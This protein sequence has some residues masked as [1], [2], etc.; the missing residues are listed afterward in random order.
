MKNDPPVGSTPSEVA[1]DIPAM[2]SEGE[3]VIP[4]DVVRY[5]GLDKIRAMMQEAKHGLACMEDEGLIVDVD[6]EGRPQKDQ[7][8]KSDDKVAIIET[9]QIEKV[10]PMMTQMAEG[11]MT[12]KDSPVSS[13]ILN[14][15]NKP[16][17][18]EGGM[19]IGPDGSLRMAMQEGGM[20]MQME[21]MM[22]EEMPSEEPEMAM[23][24]E[25]AD[26][27]A[28]QE[29]EPMPEAPM[30]N[31]PVA[32][33]ING[34]PHL[35]AYLQ[36]DEIKA[37][38]E[39]GRGLDE[40]GEQ[41]LSPEG[42]PVFV[43]NDPAEA[44]ADAAASNPA[45]HADG[46]EFGGSQFGGEV[47]A[48]ADVGPAGTD[49]E[50]QAEEF[51]ELSKE[52]KEELSPEKKDK[53]YVA[54]VGFIDKYIKERTSRPNPLQ[55]KPAYAVSAV[56]QGG[57]MRTP[58]HLQSGGMLDEE[59]NFGEPNPDVEV[60]EA[61]PDED[62]IPSVASTPSAS[63]VASEAPVESEAPVGLMQGEQ[64]IRSNLFNLGANQATMDYLSQNSDVAQSILGDA[65]E[66]ME[67]SEI[68][69]AALKHFNE[70][71]KNEDRM[72]D[73]LYLAQQRLPDLVNEEGDP[74]VYAGVEGYYDAAKILET[75]PNI[76]DESLDY[77]TKNKD[78]FRNAEDRV[79]SEEGT[80]YDDVA[81]QHY[82]L[83][84]KV[85]GDRRGTEGLESFFSRPN[86][87]EDTV[88]AMP[89]QDTM[90]DDPSSTTPTT[91]QQGFFTKEEKDKFVKQ[92][93]NIDMTGFEDVQKKMKADTFIE[94][95][96]GSFDLDPRST[97]GSHLQNFRTADD[98]PTT[99]DKAT[100]REGA[101][102]GQPLSRQLK[103]NIIEAQIDNLSNQYVR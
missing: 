51:K 91:G 88:S 60:N 28:P 72:G 56:A 70:F 80:T 66:D 53:T 75:Q 25:L 24:P 31:A 63:P 14:P 41:K 89:I 34:V 43:A 22:M 33:V 86:L 40:N 96:D 98:Q 81:K 99:P 44:A 11:G 69:A 2:I 68:D 13:P 10:D 97:V 20:P 47:D 8:E 102:K 32:Q 4:A 29:A 23:P 87:E 18:A 61:S 6:E 82:N 35:M 85:E 9:V 26:E 65:G 100:Y 71:G 38:Q 73:G 50:N 83:Y 62:P 27:M 55:G 57:L 77:L 76:S 19:V 3:F 42:I 5:V 74:K 93:G 15:E 90:V 7:K 46:S 92:L 30:M 39:A 67:G 84:G 64:E 16:V 59:N 101:N 36:E 1:D 78:V 94:R 49:S 52:V 37:L 54:G 103:M 58:V 12:D 45:G 79:A 21:D 95:E 17:M 48:P